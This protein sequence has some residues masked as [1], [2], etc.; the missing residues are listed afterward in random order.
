MV[1]E[2][3][4]D[5]RNSVRGTPREGHEPVVVGT[6]CDRSEGLPRKRV[7]FVENGGELISESPVR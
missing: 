1:A 3:P 2:V 5:A 7:H 6:T 4:L